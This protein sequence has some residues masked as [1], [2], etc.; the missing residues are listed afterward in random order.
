MGMPVY[1]GERYI[2]EALKSLLA[3]SCADFEIVISD[4]ASTDRTA[5]ICGDYAAMDSRI[6]YHR[7]PANIGLANN[8]N[9][10]IEM[11]AGRWFL[12]THCD[13]IRS[14]VYLERSIEVLEADRGVVLCYSGT[15]DIDEAG[16][17]LSREE[18]VL[19]FDAPDVRTRFRD[20][21]RLD[22][23]CEPDFGLM[24]LDMVRKTRLYGDYA[25]SDRVFLAEMGLRGRFHKISEAL[26]YRRAHAE[27]S[28]AVAPSRQ[29]RTVWF[30]PAKYRGKLIFPHFRE[31]EDLLVAVGRAPLG[32]RDRVA[33]L[34]EVLRWANSYRARLFSDLDFAGR[35]LVRPLYHAIWKPS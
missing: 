7:Q 9:A 16:R 4:N 23:I 20:I 27:Q 3:Q 22:H 25:D 32:I 14:P 11:A 13:D 5:A 6:R 28:T 15:R 34:A 17:L 21:I 8:Q 18:P 33:C 19:K 30:N 12:M 1:N 29:A 10:V 2:E 26:F 31:M 24:R 35:Q